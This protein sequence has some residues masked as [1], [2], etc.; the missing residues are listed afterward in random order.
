MLSTSDIF[1]ILVIQHPGQF[2]NWQ[3]LS[4]LYILL[5]VLLYGLL[6]LKKRIVTV[7]KNIWYIKT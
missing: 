1:A 5:Q 6:N 4:V 7:Y 2:M 3:V